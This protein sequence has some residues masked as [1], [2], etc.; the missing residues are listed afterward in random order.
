MFAKSSISD[1]GQGS[2]CVSDFVGK[3]TAA[4]R[5]SYEIK[6]ISIAKKGADKKMLI[7]QGQQTYLSCYALLRYLLYH[8]STIF[9]AYCPLRFANNN[10]FVRYDSLVYRYF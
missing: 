9:N 4:T 1:V 7:T 5:N 8:Q 3:K 2:E 10:I 6:I